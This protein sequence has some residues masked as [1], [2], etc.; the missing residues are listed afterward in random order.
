MLIY[1]DIYILVNLLDG[2]LKSCWDLVGLTQVKNCSRKYIKSSS[3][4]ADVEVTKFLL[5]L[6]KMK[7]HFKFQKTER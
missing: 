3:L 7:K 2:S 4:R 1:S 6:S 5:L